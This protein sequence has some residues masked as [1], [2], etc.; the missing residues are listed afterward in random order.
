LEN[1]VES[2]QS[3]LHAAHSCLCQCHELPQPAYAWQNNS[4]GLLVQKKF[5]AQNHSSF[6]AQLKFSIVLDKS[7]Q[8]Q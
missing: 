4:N 5:T 2:K 8:V 3:P 7:M 6:A 1:Y